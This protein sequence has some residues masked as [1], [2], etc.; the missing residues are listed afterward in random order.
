MRQIEADS[1]IFFFWRFVVIVIAKWGKDFLE[2]LVHPSRVIL[3]FSWNGPSNTGK[4][5]IKAATGMK[6]ERMTCQ[7]NFKPMMDCDGEVRT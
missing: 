2:T 4:P 3:V 5:R 7:V 6:S 1:L